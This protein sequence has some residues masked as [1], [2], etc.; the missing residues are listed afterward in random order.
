MEN[1]IPCN[2]SLKARRSSYP[3]SRQSELQ[4]KM[5]QRDKKVNTYWQSNKQEK[6]IVTI[7]ALNCIISSFTKHILL[8]L[9][10]SYKQ[11]NKS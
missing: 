2:W 4:G 7:Y 1:D 11:Q 9:K 6:T 5:D 3:T 8:D 10:K